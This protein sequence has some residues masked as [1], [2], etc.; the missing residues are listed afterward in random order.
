MPDWDGAQYRRVN[1]LQQWLAARALAGLE[2]DGVQ[3]LLDVGCGDGR[4]TAAIAARLEAMR[5]ARVVGL[6]ASPKMISIAPASDRLTFVI[7]DV[8]SMTFQDEFD[9]V[10]SFNALHWVLDQD[11]ALT[12]IAAALRRRA[13][14][15]L[16]FVCAGPRPSLEQVAMQTTKADRWARYFTHYQ[17]PFVHPEV[18]AWT[19]TAAGCGLDVRH[20]DVED[21]SWD[22]GSREAFT[23]WCTVGFGGWTERLP[24]EAGDDFVADVVAAYERAVGSAQVFRF[25]QLRADLTASW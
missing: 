11:A 15:L 23:N 1:T 12:R 7:G 21:L 3:S 9:A 19:S 18:H 25:M 16:V 20:V 6:D 10:V 2:L 24:P 22:F 8:C 13:G 5:P 17:A 4:I 14:A